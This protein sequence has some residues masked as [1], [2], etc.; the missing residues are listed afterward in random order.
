MEL[1]DL[2]NLENNRKQ[3][4]ITTDTSSETS[5]SYENF[6]E[7]TDIIRKQIHCRYTF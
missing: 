5:Y 1:T 3:L 4:D 2:P 7:Y 6:N